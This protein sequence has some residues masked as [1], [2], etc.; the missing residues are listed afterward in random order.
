MATQLFERLN[1]QAKLAV[2]AVQERATLAWNAIRFMFVRPFY[3]TDVMQQ[4]D[5]IGVDSLF[6]VVLTGFFKIGRAHV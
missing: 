6:I 3:A 2:Y 5:A 1:T 4:M